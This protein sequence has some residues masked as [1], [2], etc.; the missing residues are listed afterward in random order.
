MLPSSP[1]PV[2]RRLPDMED[3]I[4]IV[5]RHKGW[6]VAPAL[7]GLV[8]AVVTAFL[9]PNTYV[10]Q[11]AIRVVPPQVPERF[12]QSNVSMNMDQ[13]VAAMAQ[14]ILSRNT[15]T[16]IITTHDLY[17]NRRSSET[18]EDIIEDMKRD[19]V[20]SNVR[21][22]AAGKTGLTAF[23]VGFKYHN[24]F[25]AQKVASDLMRQFIDQNLRERNTQS[26]LTTQL[27]TDLYNQAK[28]ELEAVEQRIL[29]YR[30]ANRGRLPEQMQANMQQLNSLDGRMQT[31][32]NSLT[33]LS[34]DKV[35]AETEIR[36]LKEQIRQLSAAEPAAA[37]A[38]AVARNESLLRV[39]RDLQTLERNKAL[40]RQQFQPNHPD[41]RKIDG[42]IAALEREREEVV[43]RMQEAPVEAAP[44]AA[45]PSSAAAV[46]A[47]RQRDIRP[48]ES[49]IATLQSQLQQ[50]DLQTESYQ[51]EVAETEGRI[52]AL[53]KVLET[54]P[55]GDE[56]DQLVRDREFLRRK[57]DEMNTKRAQ[58]KIGTEVEQRRQGETLEMLDQ[59]GLPETPSA[60][61][62]PMIILFGAVIGI[63]AGVGFAA[64]REMKDTSLKNL[65]DVR[66]YTQL[67][68]LGSVPL[69][70]NDLVVRRR[71]RLAWLA[72]S[73]SCLLAIVVMAGSV[74]YYVSNRV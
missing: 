33:R 52:R 71:R 50:A 13:R 3:Y 65:K 59:P 21:S 30:A 42:Q 72:W 5:R 67:T 40:L 41:V 57:Y 9:W 49:R 10:S 12:I 16:F 36:N 17:K 20:I 25:L 48:L 64:V 31:L 39:E 46:A 38:G 4:D 7:V 61:N 34:Q 19:V 28:A 58:S 26:E 70:E 24:R 14:S 11:G 69:L 62:R 43:R 35:A 73:T 74:Y 44:V 18:M 54:T 56:Y 23:H 22:F 68:I 15:L 53:Q 47:Q 66:A 63:A 32:N 60:P 37:A 8:A 29:S 2:S 51:K 27:L 1:T 6:I 45:P 55:V